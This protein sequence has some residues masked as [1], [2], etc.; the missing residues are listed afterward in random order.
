MGPFEIIVEELGQALELELTPDPMGAVAIKFKN[1]VRIQM[2]V[3]DREQHFIMLAD[4]GHLPPGPYQQQITRQALKANGL[5]FP[6]HGEFAYSKK[7]EELVIFTT[8]PMDNLNG[9][10]VADTLFPFAEKAATWKEALE[11]GE[12]PPV[13]AG[14]T[15]IR[16]APGMFG[17]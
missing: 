4:L 10:H 11:R 8:L 7:K 13:Q 16:R 2:E 17:L 14:F 12:V 9:A 3:N 15:T 6:H 1:G 5:P